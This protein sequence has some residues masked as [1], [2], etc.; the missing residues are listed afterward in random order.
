MA[1]PPSA[2]PPNPL[3]LRLELE[4]AVYIRNGTGVCFVGTVALPSGMCGCPLN[5]EPEGNGNCVACSEGSFKPT[6]GN[7]RCIPK[8]FEVWPYVL[9]VGL[10][11][12]VVLS[13]LALHVYH[14]MRHQ[15]LE[16]EMERNFMA[17]M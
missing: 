1:C 7:S 6:V 3:S 13:V 5:K 15:R 10:F 14:K 16:L 4:E 2:L 12:V 9:G 8:P 11:L 17:I